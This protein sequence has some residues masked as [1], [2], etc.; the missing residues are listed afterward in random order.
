AAQIA[1]ERD[2]AALAVKV[3]GKVEDVGFKQRS[4]I[5]IDG[6][7]TAEARDTVV[8]RSIS[9][10]QAHRID[11]VEKIGSARQSHVRGRKAKLAP[12]LLA[13][14]EFRHHGVAV[15]KEARRLRDVALRQQTTYPARRDNP[16]SF[17]TERLDQ[18]D[19]EASFRAP[20]H[21]K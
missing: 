15:A 10:A 2:R 18:A 9:A 14:A 12:K 16:R 1:E 7:A 17:V 20:A 6:R 5:V 8:Q 21:E 3:G 4:T 19:A 13:V 11:A